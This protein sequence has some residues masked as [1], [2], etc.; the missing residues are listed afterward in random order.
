MSNIFFTS[1]SHAFHRNIAGPKVSN[2]DAGFRDFDD[3]FVMTDAIVKSYNDV[4]GEN[5][6]LYHLG[7]W[8]FGGKH[9][10]A[11]FRN[12]IKCRNIILIYG[13]HDHHIR[14][15]FRHLF[16]ETHELLHRTLYSNKYGTRQF[17][18]CHYSMRIWDKSHHGSL[19]C[20]GHSH[21][22]LPEHKPE[23]GRSMDV[24]WCGYRRPLHIDE[25]I[26][27]LETK[28]IP[29]LDHHNSNCAE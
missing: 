12:R 24:G 18:L 23:F 22:S 3:E 7:D 6:T 16:R 9:R 19:H 15:E 27:W 11:E 4:V 14:K 25:V 26:E 28:E 5:D 20:F 10:V 1:D 13:N 21:N 2:W 17:V 29:K 8:S